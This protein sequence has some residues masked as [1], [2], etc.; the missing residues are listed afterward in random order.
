MKKQW[1]LCSWKVSSWNSTQFTYFWKHTY[2]LSITASYIYSIKLG[3]RIRIIYKWINGI[4]NNDGQKKS[5][6]HNIN[7]H[8]IWKI[9][10]DNICSLLNLVVMWWNKNS[11]SSWFCVV[12]AKAL[13]LH[14]TEEKGKSE[15]M[16]PSLQFHPQKSH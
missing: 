4:W 10:L 6:I 9:Y 12:C 7:R 13:H 15:Q 11:S 5:N 16:C 8:L 2:I 14:K 3:A 1:T